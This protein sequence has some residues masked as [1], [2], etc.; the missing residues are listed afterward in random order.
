MRLITMHKIKVVAYLLLLCHL[1][2]WGQGEP[3]SEEGDFSLSVYGDS[4]FAWDSNKPIGNQKQYVTQAV[5][6]NEFNINLAAVK[7]SYDTHQVRSNITIQTGTYPLTNYNEP[8]ALGQLINEANIGVKIGEQSWIDIGVMS[9]HFG[10]E[11]AFS[12]DNELYTQAL[13]TEYTPYYQTGIQFSTMLAKDVALRAVV[14]NGWQN[15]FETN[16]A[17]SFG[18][19]VDYHWNEQFSFGYGNYFGN[20]GNDVTGKKYRFHN[21]LV[22][23]MKLEKFTSTISLDLTAQELLTSSKKSTVLFITWINKFDLTDY[24]SIGARYE[25]VEDPD[26]ILFE[27]IAPGFQTNVISASINYHP[28]ENAAFKIELK[29]YYGEENIWTAGEEPVSNNNFMINAG[30]AIR[31]NHDPI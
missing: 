9:G 23:R 12:L 4:Y 25:Y 20:E 26:Q 7:V 8:N 15:I 3:E 19:A 17:K 13:V 29:Q 5:R 1:N 2:V 11:S 28:R 21:N 18:L 24:L 31:I 16:N 10:Y 30:L 6:H 14:I 27:T 22:S